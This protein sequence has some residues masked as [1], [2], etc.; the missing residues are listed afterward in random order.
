MKQAGIIG[1]AGF[2]GTYITKTSLVKETFNQYAFQ[3]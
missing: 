3:L 2:I 1:G